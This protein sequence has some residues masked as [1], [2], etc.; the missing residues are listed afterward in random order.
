MSIQ[1][2][3]LARPADWQAF[4]RLCFDLYREIWGD[5]NALMHCRAGQPQAGVDVYG[6]DVR[7]R[8]TGVQCKGKNAVYGA[9]LTKRELREEVEKAKRFTPPLDVF[10][11]ATTSPSDVRIQQ[12]ARDIDHAHRAVG[13][14]EVHVVAWDTL[15]LLLAK[16]HRVARDHL[17]QVSTGTVLDALSRQSGYHQQTHDAIAELRQIVGAVQQAVAPGIG[18]LSSADAEPARDPAEEALR[19]RIK[20]AADLGNEGNARAAVQ[21]LQRLRH[22][23]WDAA[24]P[25]SRHRLVHALGFAHLAVGD[26]PEAVR[27]LR[28]ANAVDPGTPW[29]RCALAFADMLEDA[30]ESAF[31][32]ASAALAADPSMENAAVTFAHSAPT[33]M[34]VGEVET[35]IP[36]A[37]R[38]RP[39]VLMALAH[40]ASVRGARDDVMRLSEEAHARDPDDWRTQGFLGTELLR[41]VLAVEGIA[42]T[43]VVPHDLEERFRRGLSLLRTAWATVAA[44][45][46][47]ARMPEL[48]LN[49]SGALDVAGDEECARN[50]IADAIRI[51]PDNI[52]LR[53]RRGMLHA[54]SGEWQE[55]ILELARVPADQLEPEERLIRVYVLLELGK[56]T[57][58]RDE[59]IRL[60]DEM[61]T[62]RVRDGAAGAALRADIAL[63]AGK[64]DVLAAL[65]AFPNAMAVRTAATHAGEPDEDLA[66]RLAA[67]VERILAG[68]HDSRDAATGAVVLLA[69]GR[70]SRAADLLAPLAPADRD[71][72][73]L[74]L[75]L[76]CLLD[77]DRRRE[78]R[79]LFESLPRT[80]L[81]QPEYVDLGVRLYDQIGLLA[82]ARSLV[83]SY[84]DRNPDDLRVRL[85]WFGLS[86][87]LGDTRAA[88]AWLR[89]VPTSVSGS[90][91]DL[92]LLAHLLDRH[93]AD[94]RC[95]AI[96]YRALRQDFGN[97]RIHL[98]YAFGLFLMRRVGRAIIP[99]T[100]VVGPDTAVTLVECG[101]D[102][103]LVR[104]IE[105]EPG[106][107]VERNEIPP[108]DPL[109]ARLLGLRVSNEVAISTYLRGDVRFRVEAISSKYLHAHFDVLQRFRERFPEATGF[110]TVDI[111]DEDDADRFRE[112]FR[113]TRERAEHVGAI[114]ADYAAGRI[115]LAHLALGA[116]CSVF[117]IWDDYRWRREP[118]IA[119]ALGNEPERH[120][121]LARLQDARMCVLDPLAV[122]VATALGIAATLEASFPRLAVTQSTIDHL[123]Q[124]AL[125][126]RHEAGAG[127]RGSMVW[128]GSGV[129][130]L[131][132]GADDLD[133]RAA[134]MEDA[135]RFARSCQLVTAEA[136]RP[137]HREASELYTALP[138]ANLDSLLAAIGADGVLLCEDMF[139]RHLGEVASDSKGVWMQ[140]VLRHGLVT[141]AISPTDYAS[142]VGLLA[143]AGHQFTSIGAFELL[144]EFR[145]H[146]WMPLGRI[147]L[148]FAMLA[149]PGNDQEALVGVAAE[150]LRAAWFETGGDHRFRCALWQMLR[151]FGPT[152]TDLLPRLRRWVAE[153]AARI[154]EDNEPRLRRVTLLGSTGLSGK[155]MPRIASHPMLRCI[156]DEMAEFL[157]WHLREHDP[158]APALPDP[159]E[160]SDD[161][162]GPE[163]HTAE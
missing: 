122:Y 118:S 83:R 80:L 54:G 103:R 92:M 48:A 146:L 35:A 39:Q 12:V 152:R 66:E 136:D 45:D 23:E 127:R 4:E 17:G 105:T 107:R 53:R 34:S 90:S 15:Q 60:R 119:C 65:D 120:E 62:G 101:G 144:H 55:A 78:A 58:A 29:S 117:D 156:S 108:D 123:A 130:L 79:E 44:N 43:K 47:G 25:R 26:V 67:D 112:V 74:R 145:R 121:A 72:P 31:A 19:I 139:L 87:R 95:F 5:P 56:A 143:D 7:G 151:A 46:F 27:Q 30:N 133:R 115:S 32:H 1:N 94:A 104:V 16:H 70:P 68:P 96:G 89:S 85:V 2:Q 91:E 3:Q 155:R 63:G 160:A 140:A 88:L 71:T 86:E 129:T 57:E 158:D 125:E 10:L 42:L 52:D 109:A 138:R 132:M 41:P 8:L 9:E 75:R 51:C 33:S 76:R 100:D 113:I 111:G 159:G 116:G 162:S 102:D 142:A 106:P 114:A 131:E 147:Q 99:R 37:L 98:S 6:R 49:L 50:V 73:P 157:G 69:I 13:L 40:A 38:E 97:P 93:L 134:V 28:A 161:M 128:N 110:G 137:I 153:I 20:D 148:Y 135:V 36:A 126:R 21:Q 77:A 24:S 84:L 163:R 18:A 81:A 22:R 14:F 59:A 141:R 150:F 61:P 149:A 64:A 11:L 124:A 154:V 82:R